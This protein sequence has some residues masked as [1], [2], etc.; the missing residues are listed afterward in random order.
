MPEDEFQRVRGKYG[1]VLATPMIKETP[2]GSRV[3]GCVSVDAPADAF[4]A[5]SSDE[6]RGLVAAAAVTLAAVVS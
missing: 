6:V 1:V 5:M 2:L 4:A 3:V